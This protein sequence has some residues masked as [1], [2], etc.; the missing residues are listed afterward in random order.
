MAE[1]SRIAV[2][3]AAGFIGNRAVEMLHLGGGYQVVPV[4][5]RASALALASRFDLQPAIADAS[6][7]LG[8]GAG[9]R[10]LRAGPACGRRRPGHDRRFNR[11]RLSRGRSGRRRPAHLSQQRLGARTGPRPRHRRAVSHPPVSAPSYN[12][13]KASAER[14]LLALRASGRT[15]VVILRPGIVH[16]PRS[17]WTGGLADQL[18]AGE[19]FLADGGVRHLQLGLRRQRGARRRPGRRRRGCGRR[20]LPDRRRR[21]GDLAVAGRAGRRRARDRRRRPAHAVLRRDPR[22]AAPP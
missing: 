3:G 20:S 17:Q 21:D 13:A 9:L 7:Q 14:R 8:P 19:A 18:L 1:L 12:R 15:E 4:V 5:R 11:A 22:A 10:R 16:G 6:R 2:V